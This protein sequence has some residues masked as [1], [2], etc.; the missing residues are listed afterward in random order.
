MAPPD[1]ALR[2]LVVDLA[3]RQPEDIASVLGLLDEAQRKIV[4][5][6][7]R[8]F[9]N[10]GLKENQPSNIGSIDTQRLSPWL[11]ECIFSDHSAM[12]D[13]SRRVLRDCAAR[14]YPAPVQQRRASQGWFGRL[15]AGQATS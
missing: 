2:R 15:F 12:T 8:E 6:M 1:R 3:A 9:S 7:L 13:A 14:L 11:A 4:E 10:F 5:D